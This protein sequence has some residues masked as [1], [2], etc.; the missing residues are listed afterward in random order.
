MVNG[1][2][3]GNSFERTIANTL[4]K[5]FE[6]YLG[7][8]SG[9]R[10]NSDSGSFMGGSNSS[11]I[12]THCL[13]YAV[14]GDLICPKKFKYSIE[15]KFYKS[16]PKFVAFLKQDITQW[17][18][19]LKQCEQDATNSKKLGACII[20]YNNVPEFVLINKNNM[21]FNSEIYYKDYKILLLDDFLK[22]PDKHYF[23]DI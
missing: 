9:F 11:R 4:S 10:R 17:D 13:D 14:F 3:K 2:Q 19:W 21:D 6:Q 5:R 12:E 8:P 15:C 16:S 22:L 23:E 18:K 7:I 1:K 20:K